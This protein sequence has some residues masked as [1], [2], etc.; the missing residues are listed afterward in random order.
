MAMQRRRIGLPL[1]N[2]VIPGCKVEWNV[3]AVH[4]FVDD[5][6]GELGRTLMHA[7]GEVVLAGAQRRCLRRTGA[8]QEAMRFEVDTDEWGIFTAVISPV[9]NKKSGFPYAIMHEAKKVRD[10]R[11]HRSLVPALRDIKKIGT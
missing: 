7:L 9:Q 3:E 2:L 10:R 8:M 5:P 11:P 4:E 6:T 1:E